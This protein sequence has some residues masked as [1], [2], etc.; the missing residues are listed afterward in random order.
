MYCEHCFTETPNHHPR[1][2]QCG[3]PFFK[4]EE[5]SQQ[6]VKVKTKG[7]FDILGW[8]AGLAVGWYSGIYLLVLMACTFTILWLLKKILKPDATIYLSTIAF[9]AGSIFMATGFLLFIV[10]RTEIP[11]RPDLF[12]LIFDF[13]VP[14]AGL[15]WLA[16]NPGLKPVV[17]LTVYQSYVL[18][19]NVY[20]FSSMEVGSSNH[21][22]LATYILWRLIALF[23]MWRSYIST[24]NTNGG[25]HEI[26]S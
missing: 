19:V 25:T 9:Q 22:A 10:F 5:I 14:I 11:I 3:K 7:N 21:K 4:H 2:I 15:I 20:N 6:T 13:V 23:I 16:L 18:I 17:F 12:Y 8:I 1:C 24:K 26:P